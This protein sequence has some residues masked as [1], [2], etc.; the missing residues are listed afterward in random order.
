[1]H[2]WEID[3]EQPKISAGWKSRFRHYNNLG[4]CERRLERLMSDFKFGTAVGVLKGLT[5]VAE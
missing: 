1:L 2:P 5:L 4:K 3:T